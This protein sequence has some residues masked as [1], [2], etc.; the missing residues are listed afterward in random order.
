VIPPWGDRDEEVLL[1]W[2]EEIRIL[3][4]FGL[5][6]GQRILELGTGPGTVAAGLLRHLPE[7][8]LV[9]VDSAAGALPR[10]R[11]AVEGMPARVS[12]L[13]GTPVRLPFRAETFDF[14]VARFLLQYLSCP[15]DAARE[16][17]RVL[18]PGGHVALTDVDRELA[19]AIH[20]ELPE[21]EVLMSRYDA[22]HR[23]RGGDRGVGAR[24]KE[25]LRDAGAGGVEAETVRFESRPETAELFLDSLMGPSRLR[26]LRD[27]GRITTAD[28]DDF[29]AA[30]ARWLLAPGR[31]VTRYLRMACAAR[32][33]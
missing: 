14:V 33:P 30:R 12:L 16:A 19:Y 8:T 24:L 13:R 31:A 28:V 22:R 2:T 26:D 21:L 29:L 25:I 23:D 32:A 15:A 4:R 6:D 9:G 20:P 1:S 3:R 7:A 17:L 27:A 18:R 11:R 10:A 5:R